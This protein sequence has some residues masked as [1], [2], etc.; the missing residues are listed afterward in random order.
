MYYRSTI[1]E[2]VL[3]KLHTF[4]NELNR[5][6]TIIFMIGAGHGIEVEHEVKSSNNYQSYQS[7]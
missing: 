7:L 6:I 2:I 1:C 4:V 5:K 3:C